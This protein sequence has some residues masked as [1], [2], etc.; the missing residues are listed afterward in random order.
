[1]QDVNVSP[2]SKLADEMEKQHWLAE[3]TG[4]NCTQAQCQ[5]LPRIPNCYR[6]SA[7]RM[8]DGDTSIFSDAAGKSVHV[9]FQTLLM[10]F[11]IGPSA[12]LLLPLAQPCRSRHAKAVPAYPTVSRGGPSQPQ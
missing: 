10:R 7:G 11:I 9:C 1:M 8:P 4:R 12:T 3:D 5:A 6:V 2:V